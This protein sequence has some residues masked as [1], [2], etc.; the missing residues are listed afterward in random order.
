MRLFIAAP[1]PANVLAALQTQQAQYH[2]QGVRL[3]PAANLHLT[4]H[5][6]GET[7]ESELMNLTQPLENIAAYLPAFTLT[8]KETA[9]GP[10]LKSPRLVWARFHDHPAF[11][12]LARTIQEKLNSSSDHPGEYIP[13]VTIARLKKDKL[14]NLVLPVSQGIAFPDFPVNSFGIWQSELGSPHPRYRILNE[15]KLLPA[16]V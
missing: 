15:F 8:F 4:L 11:T 3:V 14:S 13:H 12:Q 16:L 6:L 7:P 10:K 2:Q 1:L 9:P 5:F